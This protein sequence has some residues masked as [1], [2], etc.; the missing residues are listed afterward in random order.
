MAG[1]PSE[2]LVWAMETLAPDPGDHVLEVGCGHGVA[3]S[4]VCERLSGGRILAIDRSQ[5]M[6]EMATRRNR[7]H[8]AA[9]RA[10]LKTTTLEQADLGDE[11][12]DKVFAF[13]VAPFWLQPE[14][15]LGI[16]R[17]Q[18]APGG[19]VY[20]F[21]DARHTQSGRARDL[22]DAL[23]ER[24]RLAAFCVEQVLVQDLRPVPAV[25]VIARPV[26]A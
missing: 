14:Q 16:V 15:A 1:K 21:W 17:R 24:I 18:L 11:R 13:N 10:V 12:F 6:I 20:V 25:C 19:A 2:R 3:V 4:L 8:V 5:K 7:E 23:S 22:A 9:G 26:T